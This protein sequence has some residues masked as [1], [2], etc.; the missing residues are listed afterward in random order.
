MGK[1]TVV[2]ISTAVQEMEDTTNM[3]EFN[4]KLKTGNAI[5]DKEHQELIQAVNKLL[6]ACNSG[7]GRSSMDETIKFLNNYVQQ[8]FAHEE[9][10]QERSG[11]PGI[12]A[13]KLFHEN[14]KKT[15]KEITSRIS[16]SGSGITELINLNKHIR[17]LISHISTEDKKL[18]AF[19]NQK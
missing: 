2:K 15:L 8:H 14:Y 1:I 13:H 19:L 3:Y 4:E 12:A 16:A 7:K 18:G 17:V 6:E 10:L 5:I 9:Q 11:Y